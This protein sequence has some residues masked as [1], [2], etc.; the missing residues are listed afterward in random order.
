M[1]NIG[2]PV[3][4]TMW[5]SVFWSDETKIELFGQNYKMYVC[6]IK[7]I[8]FTEE[9]ENIPKSRCANKAD[10]TTIQTDCCNKIKCKC[11]YAVSCFSLCHYGIMVGCSFYIKCAKVLILFILWQKSAVVRVMSR[12]FI[13]CSLKAQGGDT[14]QK[15]LGRRTRSLNSE[16]VSTLWACIYPQCKGIFLQPLLLLFGL[17]TGTCIECPVA[18][19][20]N[21]YIIAIFN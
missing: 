16:T 5:K 18:K 4:K 1:Q 21:T 19:F 14:I 6:T 10:K 3:S 12:L 17:G 20:W 8:P 9:W 7:T 11:T 13:Y 2:Y 15:C